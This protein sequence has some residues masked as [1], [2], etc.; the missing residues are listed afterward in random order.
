MVIR[1]HT[2]VRTVTGEQNRTR[3]VK[4]SKRPLTN[5]RPRSSRFKKGY[6]LGYGTDRCRLGRRSMPDILGLTEIDHLLSDVLPVVS[7]SF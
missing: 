2:V 3:A 5:D 7:N 6:K 1:I 4:K